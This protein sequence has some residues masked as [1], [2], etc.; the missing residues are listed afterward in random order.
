LGLYYRD[1]YAA[2][3]VNRG[4]LMCSVTSRA[5][6]ENMHM[7][8]FRYGTESYPESVMKRAFKISGFGTL[9]GLEA[10]FKTHFRTI[11]STQKATAV[12][13]PMDP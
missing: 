5:Q 2:L 6:S 9:Y 8:E 1:I 13:K 12:F 11:L 4:I 3:D 7:R 10:A